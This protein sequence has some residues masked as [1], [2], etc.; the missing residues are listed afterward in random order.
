M[1]MAHSH[2]HENPKGS[3]AT[4]NIHD[5]LDKGQKCVCVWGGVSGDGGPKF[6]K[7]EWAIYR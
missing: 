1:C 7:R 6:Q 2:M 3:E 5:I 4:F